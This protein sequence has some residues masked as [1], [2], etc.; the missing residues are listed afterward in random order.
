MN[1]ALGTLPASRMPC[2]S[3]FDPGANDGSMAEYIDTETDGA[4]ELVGRA[5]RAYLAGD[6][7]RAR[8]CADLLREAAEVL[9]TLAQEVEA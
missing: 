2:P 4:C 9:T 7:M 3:S 1:P 5:C 8:A 6:P